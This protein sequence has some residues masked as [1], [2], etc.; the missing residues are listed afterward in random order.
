MGVAAPARF[1]G[2]DYETTEPLAPEIPDSHQI[3]FTGGAAGGGTGGGGH[4]K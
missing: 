2:E 4:A 1:L 3:H